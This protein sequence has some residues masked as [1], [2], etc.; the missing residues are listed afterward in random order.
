MSGSFA[1]CSKCQPLSF[2]AMIWN[3]GPLL[4]V[5]Y[6]ECRQLTAAVAVNTHKTYLKRTKA[7]QRVRT[8]TRGEIRARTDLSVAKQA[9]FSK[10]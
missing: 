6:V 7:Q 8:D 2:C 10:L 9:N 1:R 4:H 5:L 3:E